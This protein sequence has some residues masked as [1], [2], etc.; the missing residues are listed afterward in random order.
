MAQVTADSGIQSKGARKAIRD[1]LQYSPGM[2]KPQDVI[3]FCRQLASFVRVGVPVTTAIATFAEQASTKRLKEAYL[4]VVAD[5]EAGT[6]LSVAFAAHPTVFPSILTD[7]IRS[8]EITGN[9]SLIH[10]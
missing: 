10:I 6:R 7:M 8:A 1:F 9:L 3:L 2:V 4:A 5:L